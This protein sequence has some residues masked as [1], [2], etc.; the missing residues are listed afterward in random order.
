MVATEQPAHGVDL[1]GPAPTNPDNVAE[2][3]ES[4]LRGNSYLA[5]KNVTCDFQDGVLTLR[6][7]LPTYYLKQIAQ[8]VVGRLDGVQRI[9]NDIQVTPARRNVSWPV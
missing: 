8:A 4:R 6:G 7:C 5:L 9:V 1:R 3:A 2:R